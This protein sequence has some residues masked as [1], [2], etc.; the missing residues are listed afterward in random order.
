MKR[1]VLIFIF[2]VV[3]TPSA[4]AESIIT[5]EVNP[6]GNAVWDIEKRL[7]LATQAEINE[8]IWF[9]ERG[10]DA[11]QYETDV[12]KFRDR[13]NFS[14]DSAEKFS[15][16]QMEA[17]NFSI[18]YDKFESLSG[19]FGIIHYNFEW[20]NFSHLDT[21]NIVI[22]DSFSEGM[23]ISS[24]NVLVIMIPEGYEISS[25]S[26]EFEKRDGNRL[27]WDGTMYSTFERGE[28]SIVL[29]PTATPA[30]FNIT[31]LVAVLVILVSVISFIFLKKR[32]SRTQV[33][34]S[35]NSSQPGRI[36]EDIEDEELINKILLKFGGE[37]FQ[38]DIVRESG[39][40]KSKI[41]V[42]LSAMKDKG[43]II[44]IRK[45]KENLIRLANK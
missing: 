27:I 41:S 32:R 4:V 26:P 37:A 10:Q 11:G 18:S 9:I 6:D 1:V 12:Q 33:S 45:S 24:D 36:I 43:E 7:D 28:P 34:D 29:S 14:L 2:L 40:S 3:W 8:W 15:D 25:S 35:M 22:G 13:I 31:P 20:K 19:T 38:S 42:V 23:I 17:G 16:R 21:G 5:V 39:F 30:A 44:K